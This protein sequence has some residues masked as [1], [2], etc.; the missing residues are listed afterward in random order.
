[1]PAG[2]G[3]AVALAGLGSAAA[4]LILSKMRCFCKQSADGRC[5]KGCGF[6]NHS[7]FDQTEVQLEKTSI[8]GVDVVYVKKPA[9]Q[10]DIVDDYEVYSQ[11]SSSDP[12]TCL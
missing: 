10:Q 12:D 5:T 1:M 3:V 11:S 2:E 6:T 9:S 4:T 7:L 8:N